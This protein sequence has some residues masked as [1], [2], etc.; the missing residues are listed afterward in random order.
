LFEQTILA[1]LDGVNGS[2]D[3]SIR[4]ERSVLGVAEGYEGRVTLQSDL[5]GL[6]GRV[7]LIDVVDTQVVGLV[8]GGELVEFE[9]QLCL[10]VSVGDVVGGSE[11]GGARSL[12][13]EDVTL[14]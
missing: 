5:I 2:L 11:G 3:V 8:H 12:F 7:K 9:V 6:V 1:S 13:R 4:R 10:V 14:R